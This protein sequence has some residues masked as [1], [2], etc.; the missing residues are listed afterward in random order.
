MS[1]TIGID[2]GTTNLCALLAESTTYSV[3]EVRSCKNDTLIAS[4]DPACYEQ[5]ATLII[6]KM[7]DLLKVLVS[8]S[9]INTNEISSIAITGQMHGIVLV[10]ECL[11]PVT[12][13]Y[14][15]RDRRSE[16]SG[17]LAD[18][19]EKLPKNYINNTGCR[20]AAGFGGLTLSWLLA[21]SGKREM[22][23]KYSALSIMDYLGA[24]LTGKLCTD[25][26]NAA[27]WGIF[28]I[29]DNVWY[30][31][32]LSAMDIPL[33]MLPDIVSSGD[34]IDTI[35]PELAEKLS[36]PSNLKVY[37]PIGDNQASYFGAGRGKK[38]VAVVNVGTSGQITVPSD[39]ICVENGLETRPLPNA[40]YILVGAILCGGWSYD[41]LASF[42]MDV[43]KSL[44]EVDIDKD[45]VYNNMKSVI[46]KVY[47]SKGAG[48]KVDTK[49]S[50]T[51]SGI[52]EQTGRIYGIDEGNLTAGNL[53]YGFLYGI[54]DELA[55]MLP[56]KYLSDDGN[57]FKELIATGNAIRLNP[58]SLKMIEDIFSKKCQ[59]SDVHEEAA[60]GAAF[61]AFNNES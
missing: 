20:L 45:L 3:L 58:I 52:G 44:G 12:P 47:S 29:V 34:V 61:V 1:Y 49:F 19:V 39:S 30:D 28:N 23:E 16:D 57:A 31:D 59:L 56:E 17:Y 6:E 41:Y 36:L 9:S 55:E 43:I 51:R 8:N 38:G 22:L 26:S 42:F 14:T 10:N 4:N 13:F 2:I 35:L 46:E 11:K 33:K 37:I 7:L 60:A 27:G 50:G 24:I 18:L 48:L 21:K 5:D 15:W 54:I 25:Y 40:G 32:L 53:I